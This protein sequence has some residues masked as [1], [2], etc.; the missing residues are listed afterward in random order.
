[1]SHVVL[2]L[3]WCV[4]GYISS[5]LP[6]VFHILPSIHAKQTLIKKC[7]LSVSCIVQYFD[8]NFVI[9]HHMCKKSF[10]IVINSCQKLLICVLTV[11]ILYFF[12]VTQIA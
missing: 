6:A 9:V 7:S 5:F 4:L 10:I 3:V 1:M 12:I 8:V 2:S 11:L